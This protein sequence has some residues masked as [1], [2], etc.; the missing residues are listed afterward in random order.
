MPSDKEREYRFG[1]VANLQ[2]ADRL[3]SFDEMAAYLKEAVYV[4][5]NCEEHGMAPEGCGDDATVSIGVDFDP[6][7]LEATDHLCERGNTLLVTGEGNMVAWLDL[8]GDQR[9]QVSW[10]PDNYPAL[11]VTVVTLTDA[12]LAEHINT[13]CGGWLIRKCNIEGVNV[14]GDYVADAEL[15]DADGTS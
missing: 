9:L 7:L 13:R 6:P 8:L 1:F 5:L 12:Q 14:E 11:N 4:D 2:D 15:D 3:P 10:C